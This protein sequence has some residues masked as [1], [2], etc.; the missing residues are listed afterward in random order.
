MNTAST[1]QHFA[2]KDALIKESLNRI[3]E[4]AE[5][6]I[7]QRGRFVLVLAGGSTPKALYQ[8]LGKT[9]QDWSKWYLIYGDERYLPLEHPDRNHHMVEESFGAA[10]GSTKHCPLPFTMD[11]ENDAA[12]YREQVKTLLPADFC[13]LGIGEDGH[14]AS[15]FPHLPESNDAVFAVYKAPKAPSERVSLN[16]SALNQSLE[17]LLLATGEEKIR[18]IEA[19]YKKQML[20]FSRI[21]GQE[22]TAIFL[23]P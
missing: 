18:L 23:C 20:P 4:S 21:Q 14:T 2:D 12:A 13:L 5:R 7:A 15:L 16:Y 8:A 6:A 11:I 1:L 10:I 19:H 9:A 17:V 3:V 22:S